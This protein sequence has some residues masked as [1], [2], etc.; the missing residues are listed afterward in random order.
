MMQFGPKN[1]KFVYNIEIDLFF[2]ILK[3]SSYFVSAIF[4]LVI[5]TYFK[6][7]PFNMPWKPSNRPQAFT[8]LLFDYY[9]PKVVEILN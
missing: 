4:D 8:N 5:V 7:S 6:W 3:I 9:K 2:L 1:D